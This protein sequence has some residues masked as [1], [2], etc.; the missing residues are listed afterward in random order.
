M[1]EFREYEAI[2]ETENIRHKVG[3]NLMTLYFCV[4]VQ[5]KYFM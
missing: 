4:I 1:R 5:E 2:C 3:T